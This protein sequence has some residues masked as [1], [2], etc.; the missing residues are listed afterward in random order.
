MQVVPVTKS[1]QNQFELVSDSSSMA[2]NLLN[3]WTR[4]S[5]QSKKRKRME[6]GLK[7]MIGP[8]FIYFGRNCAPNL[9]FGDY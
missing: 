7:W 2:C 3:P 5:A 9:E 8:I 4:S 1:C 6:V